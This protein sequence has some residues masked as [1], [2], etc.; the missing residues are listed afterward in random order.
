MTSNNK[1]TENIQKRMR[2]LE[3][4]IVMGSYYD[5]WTLRGMKEEYNTLKDLIKD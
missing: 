4:E 5:G 2:V 3:Q 1:I